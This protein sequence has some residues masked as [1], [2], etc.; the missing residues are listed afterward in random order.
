MFNFTKQVLNTT[1]YTIEE[2]DETVLLY[3]DS[4]NLLSCH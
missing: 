3:F 2:C 1:W 4:R